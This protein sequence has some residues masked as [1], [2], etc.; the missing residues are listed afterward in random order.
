MHSI[1]NIILIVVV[2]AIPVHKIMPPADSDFWVPILVFGV[3]IILVYMVLSP[4]KQKKIKVRG[5]N[6]WFNPRVL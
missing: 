1:A 4:N 2:K 6:R 3:F 5:N